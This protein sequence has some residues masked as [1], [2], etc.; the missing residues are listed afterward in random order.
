MEHIVL[1]QIAKHQSAN[2]IQIYSQHGF[3]EKLS[4]VI[5]LISSCHD[6]TTTIQS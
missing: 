5:Q 1:S 4:S 2:N 3:C 6:W